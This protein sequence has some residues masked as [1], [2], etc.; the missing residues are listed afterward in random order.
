MAQAIDQDCQL[1]RNRGNHAY[2][3]IFPDGRQ[4]AVPNSAGDFRVHKAF[5][6]QLRQHGLIIDGIATNRGVPIE[7]RIKHSAAV[8]KTRKP[9]QAEPDDLSPALLRELLYADEILSAVTN[10]GIMEKCEATVEAITYKVMQELSIKIADRSA[11]E[12]RINVEL[13]ELYAHDQLKR[14]PRN[15][16]GYLYSMHD[17]QVPGMKEVVEKVIAEHSEALALLAP[18]DGPPIRPSNQTQ[19]QAWKSLQQAGE[20]IAQFAKLMA[21]SLDETHGGSNGTP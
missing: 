13:L 2:K 6:V 14:R 11:L 7:G 4:L 9:R 17:F 10:I 15:G 19:W 5:K 18:H 1:V 12:A 3:L 8:V 21:Q 16:G 20:S